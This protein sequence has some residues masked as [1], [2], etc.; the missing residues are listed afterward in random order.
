MEKEVFAR[1]INEIFCS[2]HKLGHQQAKNYDKALDPYTYRTG[3]WRV[4]GYSVQATTKI[5]PTMKTKRLDGA[6]GPILLTIWYS[7][8]VGDKCCCNSI[9]SHLISMNFYT[10][11]YGTA[12][13]AS[14]KLCGDHRVQKQI[15]LFEMCTIIQS[16]MGLTYFAPS[17]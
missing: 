17:G 11:H 10:S 14:T 16:K 13:L 6:Q 5:T 8:F 15:L 1:R 3:T 4:K 9:L 7:K 2:K 12:P